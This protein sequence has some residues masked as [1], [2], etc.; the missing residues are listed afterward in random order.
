MR[1]DLEA[2]RTS[3]RHEPLP[4]HDITIKEIVALMPA[5]A[6]SEASVRRMLKGGVIPGRKPR[7]RWLLNPTKVQAALDQPDRMGR[8]HEYL[9]GW[10]TAKRGFKAAQREARD[11]RI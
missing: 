10:R 4:S 2:L 7:G 8:I 5:G 1:Q 3:A 9:R 11:P 6:R